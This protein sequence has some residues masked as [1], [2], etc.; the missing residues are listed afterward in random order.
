MNQ[1][2]EIEKLRCDPEIDNDKI[3]ILPKNFNSPEKEDKLFSETYTY[4][5][6]LEKEDLPVKIPQKELEKAEKSLSVEIPPLSATLSFIIDNPGLLLA[7]IEVIKWYLEKR[8]FREIYFSLI[9]KGKNNSTAITYKGPPK[10]L[11]NI[12]DKMEEL[13]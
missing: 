11:D 4:K 7:A 12:L 10:D 6:L 2:I 3:N 9:V 1:K 8:K 13:T 5:K